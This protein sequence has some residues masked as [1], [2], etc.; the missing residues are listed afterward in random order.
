MLVVYV[1]SF[2]LAEVVVGILSPFGG[3]LRERESRCGPS[4]S[5]EYVQ[6]SLS[7]FLERAHR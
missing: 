5:V 4:S 3:A 7:F 2:V 6:R 1:G